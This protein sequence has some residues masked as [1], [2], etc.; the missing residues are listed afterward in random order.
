MEIKRI[1]L[2]T[3]QEILKE[4]KKPRF[5]WNDSL[6]EDTQYLSIDGRG[7]LGEKM[8]A[9]ILR[10]YGREVGGDDDSTDAERGYDIVSNGIK[11]EIKLA[12]ITVGS[13]MFQHENLNP[14]RD[15]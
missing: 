8:A 7:K 10:E 13:G 14:Q 3:I 4:T 1:V 2:D 11:L 12:T 15:F 5:D 9:Y 6:Y